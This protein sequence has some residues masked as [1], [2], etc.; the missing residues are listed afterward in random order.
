MY[1]KP[2]PNPS[3]IHS[4]W[5]DEDWD[6]ERLRET[7]RGKKEQVEKEKANREKQDGT[8]KDPEYYLPSPIYV[9][10]YS[11]VAP[12][13]SDSLVPS[14]GQE[15]KKKEEEQQEKGEKNLV[16]DPILDPD[17]YPPSPQYITSYEEDDPALTDN[18]GHRRSR[19]CRRHRRRCQTHR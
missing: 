6:G 19:R 10:S 1:T 12:A 11:K 8:Q 14:P 15:E 2:A 5:S 9:P 4:D 16:Q 13:I 18:Q 17:Y 7:E 3:P